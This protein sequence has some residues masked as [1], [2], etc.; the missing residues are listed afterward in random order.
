MIPLGI[1]LSLKGGKEALLRLLGIA[2]GVM[3]GVALLL[4]MLS[5][6]QLL[7]GTLDQPCWRCTG[8]LYSSLKGN[9]T[10]DP[11][12]WNKAETVFDAKT[13]EIYN[14]AKT[15]PN[16]PTIPGVDKIPGP[17]EYYASPALAKLLEKTP[18]DQLDDRFPEKLAGQIG[19]AGLNYPRD[20][21]A[22][23]GHAPEEMPLTP[24]LEN[25]W[26]EVNSGAPGGNNFTFLVWT[27]NQRPELRSFDAFMT[28]LFVVG[29]A[30]LL[31]SVLTLI[32]TA[33]RLSASRRES[34]FAALRLFG[35][36]PKQINQLAAIDATIGAGL[37]ALLGAGLFYL[38]R[39]AL[40]AGISS[41]DIVSFFPDDLRPGMLSMV[42]VL[43]GTPLVATAAAILSLRKVRISP[44]G[45][46]RKTTPKPPSAWRTT[47]MILGALL[48][49]GVWWINR[50]VE[51]T[52][53][54]AELIPY[55][56]I[57]FVLLLFGMVIA[58]PWLTMILTRLLARRA[59]TAGSLLAFRRLADNPVAAFRTVSVL[60]IATLLCTF[61]AAL[62]SIVIVP[63]DTTSGNRSEPIFLDQYLSDEPI[64]EI[65]PALTSLAKI[66]GVK[67]VPTYRIAAENTLA[68]ES[69]LVDCADM[70]HLGLTK[71]EPGKNVAK[72]P[73]GFGGTFGI[74]AK[75]LKVEQLALPNTYKEH[76][77][78][79]LL[80]NVGNNQANTDRVRTVLYRHHFDA[81]QFFLTRPEINQKDAKVT[82]SIQYVINGI[83]LIILFIAS[84][85]LAVSVAGALVE[86]KRPFGLLRI[87]GTS[88]RQLSVVVALESLVP[89]LSAMVIS[90]GLGFGSAVL[91]NE[92]FA[93]KD[94]P[95]VQGLP[96]DFYLIVTLGIMLAVLITL[97]TLPLL[98]AITKPE[99]ARFE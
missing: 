72:L 29:M 71:C 23:V 55:F 63:F 82:R 34:K 3:I 64:S 39:P 62:S 12:H 89:L 54:K 66:P 46:V 4:F 78:I 74:P 52:Q 35:A 36:T 16:T 17:G 8:Q 37:G 93:A 38:I 15:G 51:D 53:G 73:Y 75:T 95:N 96:P 85:S 26:Q 9:A 47:F 77:V 91:I 25:F 87:T 84:C 92:S 22:V 49:A 42:A 41:I 57:G 81:N 48:M 90:I 61:L 76:G 97:A 18:D 98:A 80:I 19:R 43:I 56:L 86:R 30:G 94:A 79:R 33:T 65:Q 2:G 83:F 44:L 32:A 10:T 40:A 69:M 59:R 6:L 11:L 20:L 1:R 13:I 60:V 24:N 88:L 14:V 67:S 31:F 45:V 5:G 70:P 21:I 7:N 68:H 28:G 99:N 50:H 27:V 58:G